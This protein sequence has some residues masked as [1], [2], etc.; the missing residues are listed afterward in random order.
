MIFYYCYYRNIFDIHRLLCKIVKMQI[1][2]FY[3]I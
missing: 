1:E 3:N 2:N